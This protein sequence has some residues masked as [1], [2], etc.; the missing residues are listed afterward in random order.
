MASGEADEDQ[1]A[2][3]YEDLREG[4]AYIHGQGIVHRDLTLENVLIGSDG[5]AVLT[6][7]G[8]SKILP[9]DLRAELEQT[10]TTLGCSTRYRCSPR[11]PS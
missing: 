10:T 3:W 4:L 2:N 9:R 7:F 6:D 1:V 8:V 11:N 5:R